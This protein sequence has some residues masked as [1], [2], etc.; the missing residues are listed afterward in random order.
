MNPLPYFVHTCPS[1][2]FSGDGSDFR[3]PVSPEL[4]SWLLKE[5]GLGTKEPG[6]GSERYV[7][8][9]KCRQQAGAG[10]L[11]V[12]DLY[13]RASWCAR[14]ERDE[15]K[16][17]SAQTE[18]VQRFE[19]ALENGAVSLEQRDTITYLVGELNRRLGSFEHAVELLESVTSGELAELA[20]RQL[21]RARQGSSE[22]TSLS[23]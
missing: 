1:C 19:R 16:E 8:A 18:A 12:A 5:K 7:L 17:R 4:K 11:E 15:A 22:N 6:S 23:D 13:L 20:R 14:V 2:L 21:E 3:G 10:P 9:A